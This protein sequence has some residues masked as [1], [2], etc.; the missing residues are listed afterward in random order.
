MTRRKRVLDVREQV[1]VRG[2]RDA[3]VAQVPAHARLRRLEPLASQQTDELRLPADS[4]LAQ[5]ADER[6]PTQHLVVEIGGHWIPRNPTS[7]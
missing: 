4:R 3:Q 5:D 7:A 1:A 2:F 6:S